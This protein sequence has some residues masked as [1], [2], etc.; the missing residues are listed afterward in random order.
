MQYIITDYK[1]T[2]RGRIELC[3]NE[4]IT[5]WFYTRETGGFSLEKGLELS[6]EQYQ[7][8]LHEIIGK[9]ATKRAMHI[10]ERQERTEYQLRE[11]LLQSN[12]PKE[13]IEDAVSYVKRYHYVDDERYA[14]TFIRYHQE[15]RSRMRIQNDL[16]QRGVPRDIIA[17]SM[18]EEFSSDE[19]G[20]IRS[21]LE[22]K[23]FSFDA[24]DRNEYR[25]MYQFLMRRGFRNS[26]ISVV[27][28]R[29]ALN[30]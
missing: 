1:K 24:A 18:E 12:Y 13:A 27:M 30:D 22:K 4:K 20:Q 16:R 29:A 17:M 5:L 10:L 26:D 8:L 15:S 6:E 3:L 28:C 19:R 25:K 21:L 23:G 11:K 2:G 14:R 9:R 7:Y